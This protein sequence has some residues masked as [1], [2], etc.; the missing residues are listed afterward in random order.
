LNC[1]TECLILL[2]QLYRLMFLV[3]FNV[4]FSAVQ[5]INK[6]LVLGCMR[7][8]FSVNRVRQ[9]IMYDVC[10]V[11]GVYSRRNCYLAAGLSVFSCIIH[12]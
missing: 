10:C 1:Y 4:D 7:L 6:T 8:R 12:S 3:C 11:S 2:A 5:F 9:K